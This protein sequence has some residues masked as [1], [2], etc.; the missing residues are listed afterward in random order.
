[1]RVFILGNGPSLKKTPF[2]KL[3]GEVT[4][5]VNKIRLLY[6]HTDWRPTYYV[7]TDDIYENQDVGWH[8]DVQENIDAG[9]YCYLGPMFYD[10]WGGI[11]N[12][13]GA[14]PICGEHIYRYLGWDW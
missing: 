10:I 14:M 7:R 1:M 11:G 9:V 12:V 4:M 5:A 8:E 13:A 6:P 3:K 2:D